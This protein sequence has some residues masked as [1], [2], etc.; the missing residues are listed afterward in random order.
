MNTSQL[1][2]TYRTKLIISAYK[3]CIKKGNRILDIGCGTGVVTKILGNYFS[4]KVTGADVKNYLIDKRIPFIKINNGKI[5]VKSNVFDFSMLND[6]L[7]HIDKEHQ[8]NVIKEAARVGKTVLLFEFEPT[9]LGKIADI[10]LNKFHYGDLYAPLSMR[11]KGEWQNLI[12]GLGFRCKIIILE[13]PF[14]YPFS[15]VAFIISRDNDRS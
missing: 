1:T 8:V 9:I 11:S 13:R 15:H 5:P 2:S 3:R 14:W 10:I 6:V 4:S 12:K 7:H